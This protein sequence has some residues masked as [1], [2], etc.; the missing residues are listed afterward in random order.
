MSNSIG[1]ISHWSKEQEKMTYLILAG[2]SNAI[3]T[4]YKKENSYRTKK[5]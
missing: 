3:D 2:N 1:S 4:R 5:D